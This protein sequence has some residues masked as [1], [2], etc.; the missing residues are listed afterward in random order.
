M[1]SMPRSSGTSIRPAVSADLAVDILP[2]VSVTHG[3]RTPMRSFRPSLLGSLPELSTPPKPTV[4]RPTSGS[5]SIGSQF[6]EDHWRGGFA[7]PRSNLREPSG[8]KL[9]LAMKT[10]NTVAMYGLVPVPPAQDS[11]TFRDNDD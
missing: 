2:E 6:S 9:R 1:H 10:L 7:P 11:H 8:L 5:A 4:G 3:L